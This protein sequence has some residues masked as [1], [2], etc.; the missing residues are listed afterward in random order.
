MAYAL[1]HPYGEDG[2]R[3]GIPLAE[4]GSQTSKRQTL[5]MCQYYCFRFQQRST[6]G[7][8]L[9]LAGHLLQQYIVD[10]YM[11]VE[12]E[13]F[14]WV[15]THQSELRTELYSGLMDAVHHGDSTS[16][17][18]G[19]SVI[20]PSS[21]TGGLRYRAQNYQDAMA[22]CRW[23]GYPDL[24]ITF[25]C[26]PK[27]KEINDML[28]LIG[29]KNDSNRVDII[30]RVFEIKLQQLIH[31]I[32]KEQPF[33]KVMAC[34]YTIEFQKRGLPHTHIL[35]FLHPSMKNPSPEYIDTIIRAE[36]PDINVD[37]DAYNA[38]KKSMLHGPCG[39]ANVSS[40]CMQQ[41]KCTKFFPK[42]F[43]DTTTIGE[44][45]FPIYR[46]RNTGIIVEKNGTLL[47]NRYVIPYNRNLSVKFDAHF[48]IELCNSTRSIKY[49]FKYINKGPDRATAVI[50]T[51]DERDEIKAYLDCRYISACEACWRIF[52]F[53]INYRYPAV[54][55]L[56]F[57]L[58]NEHTVIFEE[59][60]CIENVLSM[61]GIDKTK[62]T[63]WLETNRKNEDA[64]S[65]TYAE[66]PQHWVWNS[67]GKLWTKRKK[68][69]AVGRIYFAHPSSG[70]RFY[71]R[72]LLNFVKGSTSFECIRTINGVTYPTFKA[73]CYALGLLDDD[74][75]WIDCLSEAAVWA[76]GNE[77]RNLFVTML[78]FCQV[79]NIPELWKTHSTILS[80]DM[81]YLQRK[82]FQV[83]DLQLTQEQIESY[84]L[85]EIEGLMQK[86][87]KSLKDIDGTPQPDSS[88]TRDL[89][90]RLLNE[91][92]DYDHA[93]L[94]I[95][96]EK[97]LND[98][99]QFQKGAYD[100]ILHSVQND[101][102]RLFFISGHGGTGK[103][104]LWNT[105]TSKLRSESLIVPPVAT[106]GLASLLL[107]NGRTTHSRF[108]IPLDI[109]AESTCEIKHGTQLAKLLQKTSLIIWDE[110][111]MTHK[112]C[113]EALDKTL[114]D[115]LNTRYDNCRSKPF[116]GLTVVCGGDFRQILP[117]IPQGERVDIINASLNSS[118]LWPHFE[119]FELKQNMRL[120]REGIDEIE[121]E[122]IAS[123]DRWLLQIRDGSLYENPAQEL[124]RIPP[125]LCSPTTE[126]P[127]EGIVG[128]V[129]PSLLEN[130]KK[131]AYIKERAIL[132]PK[133]ETAHELN[134]FLMNMI[135]GEGRTYL[136]SDSVC[137][138]S[139]KADDDL[140]YP[141]EF[142]NSLRFS[143]VPNHDIRL[144][145]GTPIMLLRN[146]NQSAG[147]CNGTRLIVTRLGKWSI[148]GDIISGAKVGQNVTI[149]RIIM[150][151]KESKWPFKLNRRQLPVT[152][153][154]AMTIN[155]SQGQSLNRV[156]LY[157]PS[158]VFTHGHVYVALSRVTGIE[159]LIIVNADTEVKDQA[160]I[161]NIVYKEV[162]EN[163]QAPTRDSS[164][165][166]GISGLPVENTAE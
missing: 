128:E 63:E 84:A 68:G 111:P 42:K 91:E 81:L 10:A 6:E 141:P 164:Q 69:N 127:M 105:I 18:V 40:P 50:E 113:F 110:A 122:K 142:L 88:L 145:E 102:G 151:P 53:G 16:S 90:N 89:L 77:L 140:L 26:N 130:Y 72:M 49:L 159:G 134:D 148:R 34:L 98:L 85:V 30:C 106:S 38:V 47:D 83:P 67:K 78:I 94:K 62:F 1:I 80:E 129:Y 70:E 56:P 44:D 65:L 41:G 158:Q 96:H 149:P 116:G 136:S 4:R 92:L 74:R 163:I 86:L 97:S 131:I 139:I 137:K 152:P 162:F 73:A 156:G 66:F 143:G 61:P 9:L 150:S 161:K 27:W 119:I 55:R 165:H 48:N 43:N 76:T 120:H 82:R 118:Y 112:Y 93:A 117:V 52:Q 146:L 95:L 17:T 11:A 33:G 79:S 115:L 153:C 45:G 99:N 123:F 154:F 19:K 87:G 23:V 12:Q 22:I 138:A 75:E 29:Q 2:Y 21:H 121:A 64:R 160:L 126:N 147:L 107:P 24:F 71:M 57:H 31:Y 39:Q 100:V 35:L 103:T 157:L 13:R 135:S 46:R 25:T 124:I 114:R 59:S 28:S 3:L 101:E 20:L 5:T 58:P 108:R 15:R 14:R 155:K 125:E 133:N 60:R 37:P 144:K 132:T 8:T 51:A 54:E 36:I 109:T 166:I 104:F 32:K 7:H